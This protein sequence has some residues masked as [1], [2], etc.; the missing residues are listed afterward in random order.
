MWGEWWDPPATKIVLLQ[1]SGTHFDFLPVLPEGFLLHISFIQFP[2]LFFFSF[3]LCR[4]GFSTVPPVY[5]MN[6]LLFI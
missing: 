1:S 5:F 4:L 3:R 6:L 2:S